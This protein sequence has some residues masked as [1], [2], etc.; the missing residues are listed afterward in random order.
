MDADTWITTTLT[1]DVELELLLNGR[2]YADIAPEGAQYPLVVIQLI[3]AL[4]DE[5]ISA[6]R[7]MDVENWQIRIV[8][9]GSSYA[10]AK[11]IAARIRLILHKAAAAGV[12]GCRFIQLLRYHEFTEGAM[13]KNLILEFNIFTQ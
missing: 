12:V 11:G 4:P 5:N 10:H 13:Y 6:D 1:A 7:I 9:K 2:I 8:D 3:D